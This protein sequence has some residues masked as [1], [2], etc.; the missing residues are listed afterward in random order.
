MNQT[1][2]SIMERHYIE[3]GDKVKF[4]SGNYVGITGEVLE[5]NFNS[6]DKRAKYGYL[7]TVK[8]S[9]GKIGYIEKSE[10]WRHV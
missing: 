6:K 7:H 1:N 9:N 5:T 3:K 8:L 4:V 10:H 2:L